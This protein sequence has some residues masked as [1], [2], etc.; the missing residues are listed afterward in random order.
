MMSKDYRKN[1]KSIGTQLEFYAMMRSGQHAIMYWIFSQI[2]SPIYFHNDILCHNYPKVL[3]NKGVW[4]NADS[5]YTSSRFNWFACNLE[6]ISILNIENIYKKYSDVLRFSSFDILR[7]IMIIRD[8]FN[9]F[10][11]RY[12][13]YY[14]LNQINKKQGIKEREKDRHTNYN[15]KIAWFDKGSVDRWKEYAREF[16]GSTSFLGS[17]KL[18]IDYNRWFKDMNY[19][20]KI[21]SELGLKFSDKKLNFVPNHGYG[22]SFDVRTMNKK[23]QSMDVFN[24]WRH[25]VDDDQYIN[26]I[27]DR[28]LIDLSMQIYPNITKNIVRKIGL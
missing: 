26:I 22:S 12:R 13:I 14:R 11:S 5:D 15:S 3:T 16:L 19:R 7:K 27:R 17:Q 21:S 18:L 23:A 10:A 28:E 2:N 1:C 8:P 20:K 25:F 6:D 4:I 9:M 24:R